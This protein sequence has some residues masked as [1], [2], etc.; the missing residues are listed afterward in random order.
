M[1]IG[2]IVMTRN[3]HGQVK[4]FVI[5]KRAHHYLSRIFLGRSFCANT[6]TLNYVKIYVS[7]RNVLNSIYLHLVNGQ[8]GGWTS[9]WFCHGPNL[10]NGQRA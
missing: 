1:K 6:A 10:Y 2:P 3:Q 4:L 7:P 5:Q 9:L 8:R